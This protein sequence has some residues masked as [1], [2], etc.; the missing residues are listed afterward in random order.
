[1]FDIAFHNLLRT[2]EGLRGLK[3]AVMKRFNPC[4]QIRILS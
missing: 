3:S 2:A 4:R 1:M